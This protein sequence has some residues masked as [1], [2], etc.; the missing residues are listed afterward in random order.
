MGKNWTVQDSDDGKIVIKD[1]TG[2]S[3]FSGNRKAALATLAIVMQELDEHR[4]HLRVLRESFGVPFRM[5]H[6][7]KGEYVKAKK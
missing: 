3:R 2:A 6:R 1:L 4:D 5:G 7:G